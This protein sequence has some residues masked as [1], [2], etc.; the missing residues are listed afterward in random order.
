MGI[1]VPEYI[2]EDI[3]E[4]MPTITYPNS[5]E[6]NIKFGYGD[7]K[8]LNRY[9]ALKK[10]ASYP[11]IWLL[12]PEKETHTCQFSK[13]ER[14][15]RF[16]IATLEDRSDLL[17][18]QRYRGAFDQFLLP[19]ANLLIE[20]IQSASTTRFA[21]QDEVGIAKHPNYSEE[22]NS[23]ESGV[24]ELWDAIRLDCK[25]EFNNSCL[26]QIKWITNTT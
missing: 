14:D 21:N 17:N 10:D 4:L 3:V 6:R 13:A 20:G 22:S 24:I 12:M 8:E 7:K 23:N 2:L 1:I 9:L 19:V 25:I 16:I 5:V 11:L 18:S 26:N 15:C